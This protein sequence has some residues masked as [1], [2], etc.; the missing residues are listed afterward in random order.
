MV[1]LSLAAGLSIA[2]SVAVG[3]TNG[4]YNGEDS[5]AQRYAFGKGSN[6]S[7]QG[8]K[9][10]FAQRARIRK[11]ETITKRRQKALRSNTKKKNFSIVSGNHG[12]NIGPG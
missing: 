1:G 10:T 5:Q 9:K 3:L 2:L 12:K 4:I 6:I 7:C 11:K 8:N